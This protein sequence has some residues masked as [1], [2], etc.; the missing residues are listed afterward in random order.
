MRFK[1]LKQE[2]FVYHAVPLTR[3]LTASSD[4]IKYTKM[5]FQS[6]EKFL[7]STSATKYIFE[8]HSCV[9]TST[10]LS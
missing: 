5:F 9:T 6:R 4:L 1:N 7:L 8:C 3:M 10:T 2:E